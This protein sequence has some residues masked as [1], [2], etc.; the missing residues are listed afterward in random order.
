MTVRLITTTQN[1]IG[2]STDTKPTTGVPMGSTYL[3]TDTG[4]TYIYDA[5][6]WSFLTHIVHEEAIL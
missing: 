4:D 1:F 6:G 5:S 2:L 3:E